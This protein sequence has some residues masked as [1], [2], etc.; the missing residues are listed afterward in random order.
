MPFKPNS[1][2]K[3]DMMAAVDYRGF[4]GFVQA[5]FLD[6]GSVLGLSQFLI[7]PQLPPK[8]MLYSKGVKIDPK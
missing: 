3:S 8:L 2:L 4:R 5:K 6:G 1:L 7:L